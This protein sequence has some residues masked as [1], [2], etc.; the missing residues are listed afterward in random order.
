MRRDDE[1]GFRYMFDAAEAA[2]G[3]VAGKGRDDLDVD[4]LL[5]L[6][7][8]RSIEIVGEAGARVSEE[9]R[10]AVCRRRCTVVVGRCRTPSPSPSRG[11][12]RPPAARRS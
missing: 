3:F 5:A 6:A 8:V 7:L 1:I 10:A 4:R 11:P 9:G 2:V 12:P